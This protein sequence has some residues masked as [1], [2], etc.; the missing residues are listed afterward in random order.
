[1]DNLLLARERLTTERMLAALIVFMLRSCSCWTAANLNQVTENAMHDL[2][3][4]D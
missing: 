3:P 1:M 2:R 4:A